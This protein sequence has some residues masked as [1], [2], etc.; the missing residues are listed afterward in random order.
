MRKNAKKLNFLKFDPGCIPLQPP[1]LN[2]AEFGAPDLTVTV[3]VSV[4]ENYW[5]ILIFG[6]L[7]TY[8]LI[9]DII[10]RWRIIY[11]TH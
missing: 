4:T 7:V 5:C 8:L 10:K 3:T 11:A 6:I 9:N 1:P 2:F